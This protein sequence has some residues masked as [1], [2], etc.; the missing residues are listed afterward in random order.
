VAQLVAHLH[1]MEGVR[2]SSPL[3][4]TGRPRGDEWCAPRPYRGPVPAALIH[5][6]RHG[7]S[8]WNAARLVQGS[9]AHPPLTPLGR[10]QAEAAARAVADLVAGGPVALWTSDLV[11]A[12][13][14]AEVVAARLDG[15][16]GQP[17]VSTALR[18]QALGSLEG[19]RA[20]ELVAEET[21]PG[22]HVTE[23]CWGGGESVA[24]V[25]HRVG[26]FLAAELPDAPRHLVLVA[27]EGVVRTAVAWLRGLTHRDVDWSVPVPHG[28]V[29]TVELNRR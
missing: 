15:H 1:G 5:L 25:H 8:T 12:R 7:Q 13:R 29:T 20:G 2:G 6:V 21:P 18:E 22:V 14:T 23:V 17:R 10:E 26:S 16:D 19:R 11:R 24:D 3:S 27:H 28:S 9:T 4:S